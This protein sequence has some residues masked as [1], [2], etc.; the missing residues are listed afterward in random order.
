MIDGLKPYSSYKDL[1]V[2]WTGAVP[3]HWS[4]LPMRA[5][6]TEV[7]DR[8]HSDEQMLSVTI[9]RGVLPQAAFLEG[10]SK[11]DASKQD[12]S[13][14]K[15]V[16]PGDIVYNKMRAWQGACGVSQH[17]GIVSPA[18]VVERPRD[19]VDPRFMHHLLRTP[20][21][22][23]E[24]ERWS[25]GIASDLWSLRPQHFRLIYG[26]LPPSHEQASIVRFITR[27]DR[28]V[29]RYIDVKQKLIKLLDEERQGVI[30]DAITRGINPTIPLRASGVE[31]LGDVPEHWR[32]VALG[33]LMSVLTGFPFNSSEFTTNPTGLRLLRGINVAPGRVRWETTVRWP[34]GQRGAFSSFE[35][36]V[37][38]I[39]LGMDRPVIRGGVRVA[40]VTSEDVPSLLLQ[41]VARIRP[42]PGLLREYLVLLLSGKVFADYLAPIFTGIS[43]PHVSPE[44]IKAFRFALPGS[45]EQAA[46]VAVV[47]ERTAHL[48]KAIAMARGD[49]ALLREYRTRLIADVVTGKLDV[50]AAAAGLPAQ[51]DDL[52]LDAAQLGLGVDD[53]D[54]GP[55]PNAV[56]DEAV[57]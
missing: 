17:R 56:D 51:S 9:S 11:K 44:Q 12:R 46:I 42:L 57:V 13:S 25:Y 14:Y 5:H 31:W 52:D 45:A 29:G 48:D 22:A 32:V 19:G 6:L 53:E 18:Y 23:R 49:Q 1:G 7:A 33:R 39:V 41:R 15:L 38:D 55:D 10:S 54:D 27:A 37:G 2:G 16:V 8:N 26:C 34:L 24:A 3:E 40:V 47:L 36:A 30:R 28:V 35:L 50:R 4:V 43:V 21:F 20:G